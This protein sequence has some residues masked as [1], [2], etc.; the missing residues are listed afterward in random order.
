MPGGRRAGAGQV[1]C[2]F[3]MRMIS[4]TLLHRM[5]E[6]KELFDRLRKSL[7]SQRLQEISLSVIAAYRDRNEAY[8]RSLYA[9]LFPERETSGEPLN[10]VFQGIIRHVHPD[11]LSLIQKELAESFNSA[12]SGKIL[13]FK[14]LLTVEK[15]A[16]NRIKERFDFDYSEEYGFDESDGWYRET[17]DYV[18][19]ERDSGDEDYDDSPGFSD[20]EDDEMGFVTAVRHEVMGNLDITIGPAELESL[21][22]ELALAGR[23]ITDL[24]GLQFC[25]NLSRL[26]LSDNLISSI[27]EI[28]GLGYLTELYLAGNEISDIE[29]LSGLENLEVLDLSRNEIEDI[30][31]LAGLESLI[32]V[33]LGRNPLV[34]AGAVLDLLSRRGVTILR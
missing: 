33:N 19:E 8:L 9:T 32:F 6:D 34:N 16:K 29:P 7:D 14:T 15:E 27:H 5:T 23:G 31:P 18:Y 25:R 11:R 1:S 24:Y 3:P 12:D 13:F 17:D 10:R 26:D 30:S 4:C 2:R 22:G 20:D 28:R 21:E